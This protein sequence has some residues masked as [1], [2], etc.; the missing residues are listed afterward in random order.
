MTD[1]PLHSGH[2]ERVRK[3]FVDTGL[4]SFQ[5]HEILEM[6]LFYSVPRVNTNETGHRLIDTFKSIGNV[7]DADITEL[8]KVSGVNEKSAVL[9]NLIGNMCRD[10]ARCVHS[11]FQLNSS[12]KIKNYFSDYFKSCTNEI[13]L[14]V[15]AD[16]EMNF[17]NSYVFSADNIESESFSPRELAEILLNKNADNV[18]IGHNRLNRPPIPDDKDYET[19]K[20]LTECLKYL[21]IKTIDHVIYDCGRAFSM[22]ESGGFGFY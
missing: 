20:M 13:Y 11:S 1:K 17:L 5:P 21:G 16:N 15:T 3:R 9:I 19:T 2:R 10:Y 18:F 12:E 8:T 14:F 6:I 7:L 4:E 22:L